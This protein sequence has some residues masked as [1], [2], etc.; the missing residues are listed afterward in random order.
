MRKN[1]GWSQGCGPD[2]VASGAFQGSDTD[3]DPDS[4]QQHPDL[5]PSGSEIIFFLGGRTR[6]RHNQSSV[7][8]QCNRF[9][10]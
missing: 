4:G 8:E 1:N 2:P 7:T 10:F 6:I 5:A 9:C 3:P